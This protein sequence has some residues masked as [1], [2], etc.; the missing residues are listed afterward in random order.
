MATAARDYA[1][2]KFETS[3]RK[4]KRL[5]ADPR[6]Q[7]NQQIVSSM[8]HDVDVTRRVCETAHAVGVS[9]E[10]ELG[11]LGSLRR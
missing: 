1:F 7:R 5:Y 4:A 11:C 3:I 6:S 8:V 10:G 9:V 2:V